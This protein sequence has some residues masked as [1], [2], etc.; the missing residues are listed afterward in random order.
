[1]KRKLEQWAVYRGETLPETPFTRQ[2]WQNWGRIWTW[3]FLALPASGSSKFKRNLLARLFPNN[4]LTL[5]SHP[6][7]P[8]EAWRPS[9]TEFRVKTASQSVSS[10]TLDS[11]SSVDPHAWVPWSL[12]L[13]VVL[14]TWALWMRRLSLDSSVVEW[15]NPTFPIFPSVHTI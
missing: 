1:M 14:R 13:S 12:V 3:P 10:L 4:P 8:A 6:P 2:V 9:N 15:L 7:F 5:V 11:A